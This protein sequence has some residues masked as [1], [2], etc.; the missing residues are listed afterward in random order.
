MSDDSHNFEPQHPR[1]WFVLE[2]VIGAL[3]ILLLG[4]VGENVSDMK[5]DVQLNAQSA[6][7][8]SASVS[9]IK[10]KLDGFDARL[11]E[12]ETQQRSNP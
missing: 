6:Q 9:E 3:A 7:Y 5:T 4:W 10:A 11:R 8:V 1:T 12:L 2:R